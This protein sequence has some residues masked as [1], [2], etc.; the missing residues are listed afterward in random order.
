MSNTLKGYIFVLI[1]VL[2]MANVYI[3]SK[4]AL[5]EVSIIIFGFYWF[6][7]ALFYNLLFLFYSKRNK[8][9]KLL[10]KNNLFILFIIGII[11]IAGTIFF[12]SAIKA[13]SNPAIVSFLANLAPVLI[14]IFGV[15]ILKERFNKIEITGIF[16]TIAGA[17]IISFNPGFEIAE[18]FTKGLVFILISNLLY[19]ISTII[20]KKNIHK[21]N[22]AILSLNRVIYLFIVS[23]IAVFVTN[24]NVIISFTTLKY[25]SAGA[26]LGPFLAALAGYTAIQYI[27]A[28]RSAV[29]GSSKSLFVLL[30][31]FLY[32][33][34][35]PHYYQLIGGIIT[36]AGVLFISLGKMFLKKIGKT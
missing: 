13:M 21:I 9:I 20:S 33:G 23:L 25:I 16:L 15:L 8:Q 31:A 32:F 11:E 36:V 1:S 4:A 34:K 19:A 14:T 28:S 3:F 7:F 35:L 2:A 26:L 18:N 22:P 5:K 29:I 17:M 27:E 30:T 6:A 12:F 24:S 10:N